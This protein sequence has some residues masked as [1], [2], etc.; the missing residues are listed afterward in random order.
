MELSWNILFIDVR[1]DVWVRI[2]V[3]QEWS[4]RLEEQRMKIF[5]GYDVAAVI[6]TPNK[7]LCP[8]DVLFFRNDVDEEKT[9]KHGQRAN[10]RN[11][12]FISVRSMA[13]NI[14]ELC[15]WIKICRQN[16]KIP[17]RSFKIRVIT[18]IRGLEKSL[19]IQ[20]RHAQVLKN[21]PWLARWRHEF[22]WPT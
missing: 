4:G 14:I 11:R 22:L 13:A 9:T 2:D 18:S 10:I 7:Q 8:T 21:S 5:G 17:K 6:E 20:D 1:D 12:N 15:T 19:R 3:W 16:S